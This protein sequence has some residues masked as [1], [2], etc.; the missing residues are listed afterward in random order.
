LLADRAGATTA[1]ALAFIQRVADR[2]H[3]KSVV[4]RKFLV[5][6]RHQRDRQLR[7]DCRGIDQR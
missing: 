7:R 6:R 3:V 2:F 1:A 5:F 4:P